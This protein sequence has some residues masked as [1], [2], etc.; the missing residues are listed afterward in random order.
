M[1]RED[2][3]RVLRSSFGLEAFRP[4]QEEVSFSPS[5]VMVLANFARTLPGK[6]LDSGW[7]NS[8][9]AKPRSSTATCTPPWF[10][11]S[12]IGYSIWV[13]CSAEYSIFT[14]MLWYAAYH[15]FPWLLATL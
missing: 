10:T 11:A 4:H 15:C 12:F 2:V 1:S 9:V 6:E 7:K 14:S 8:T 3:H 5:S 13:L